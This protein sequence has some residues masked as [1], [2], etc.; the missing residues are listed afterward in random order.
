MRVRY[1]LIKVLFNTGME[2]EFVNADISSDTRGFFIRTESD[3]LFIPFYNILYV[4]M[5]GKED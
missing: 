3:Y 4:S 1:K 2:K 5:E